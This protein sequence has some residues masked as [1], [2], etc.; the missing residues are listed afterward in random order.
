MPKDTWA[1]RKR[2]EAE[3]M[4]WADEAVA[5]KGAAKAKMSDDLGA[6]RMRQD[7]AIGHRELQ[8]GLAGK[9]FTAAEIR[10]LERDAGGYDR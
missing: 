4:G 10:K 1:S 5:D 6:E 2:A 7:E 9:G 8:R 3:A